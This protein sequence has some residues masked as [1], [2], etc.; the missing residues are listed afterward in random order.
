MLFT[1]LTALLPVVSALRQSGQQSL[2]APNDD[3]FNVLTHHAH[4]DHKLRVRRHEATDS[5]SYSDAAEDSS[6]SKY[7]SGA[8]N[9]YTGYL[10]TANDTKHFYFAYF[11]SRSNPDKDPLIMWI[12]GGPGCSSMTGLFM[13][14]GP[15]RVNDFGN[16]T[17]K[18]EYSWIEA[19]NVFFLD[20]PIGVGFSYDTTHGHANGT[21]A[22]SEDIYAF[23]SI[24]YHAFPKSKDVGFSIAGESYGGH[25]I[26]IFASHIIAE[27][28]LAIEEG[29]ASDTIPLESVMIGNG[30]FDPRHQA[31]SSWDISCTN[32]TGIGPLLGTYVCKKMESYINRCEN[33]WK[34]CYEYPD[35]LICD[36]AGG[37]CEKHLDE[38]YVR[39]GRN[40]YDISKPCVGDLCYPIEESI[41][42]Y[43]N[44]ADVRD[45]FG[46][47]KAV[48]SFESCSESVFRD[49]NK[50]GD[51]NLPTTTFVTNLL[52]KGL[53]VLMYVG[54]CK[55]I[56]IV[57][58]ELYSNSC[59]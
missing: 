41:T 33:L 44:R 16:G 43:L 40:Y 1:F 19:A 58:S 2:T 3:D 8:T 12:N 31:T 35:P 25:Y 56:R 39:S 4:P 42:K 59:R 10:S 30:I 51:G 6:I 18:N 13:E 22:A 34:A 57:S 23:M 14:L 46:V 38:P 52:D 49:Y 53:R 50:L 11:D 48:G 7:C 28:E 54:T 21:F 32:V 29:R 17:T 55:Y 45:A 5:G 27:N 36:A 26:P 15:C 24:W 9:G 37:F 20:Q 47:D